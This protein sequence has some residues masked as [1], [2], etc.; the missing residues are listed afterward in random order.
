LILEVNQF[1]L[2]KYNAKRSSTR[3]RKDKAGNIIEFRLT[4]EQ[5]CQLWADAG[6][7][8]AYPYVLSRK[9]DIGHYSIDNVYVSHNLYNVTESLEN[10][11][12]DNWKI[13]AY[14]IKTGYKRSIVK[15]MIR[16]GLLVL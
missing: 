6:V 15:S 2:K 1:L 11:T 9:D 10:Q 13:T 14:A 8:P 4:F 3:A 5:W 7:R 16:R 12:D